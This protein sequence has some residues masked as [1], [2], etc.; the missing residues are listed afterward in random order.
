MIHIV[1]NWKM[2][3]N[4]QEFYDFFNQFKVSFQQ[5]KL[6]TVITYIAPAYIH[7]S[8]SKSVIDLNKYNPFHLVA[9]NVAAENNG[10]HTGEVSASML[11][12]YVKYVIVGHSERRRDF[13]ETTTVLSKKLE[14]CFKC[15]LVPIFCFGETLEQREE[16]EYLSYIAQQINIIME[17]AISK[18]L[19]D[20]IPYF[21]A[22]EPVWAIGTGTSATVL[23]ISEVHDHVRK[24]LKDSTLEEMSPQIP[25]LYGGSCTSEN[26]KSILKQSNVNGLLVGGASLNPSH[27]YNILKIAHGL[28]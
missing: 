1:A 6:Q 2:N 23:Q 4:E 25:I 9:Q 18:K 21:L 13:F 10:P 19:S 24:I 22:Y 7:L 8:K 11:T 3:K 12:D 28:Y 5:L 16:G 26:V 17:L 14:N 15:N 27:F 20:G